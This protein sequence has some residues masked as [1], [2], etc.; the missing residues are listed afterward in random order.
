M[1]NVRAALA[2]VMNGSADAAIVYESDTVAAGSLKS[3]VISGP[4][5]PRIVYPAALVT[6]A[7]NRA[8]AQR[9]LAFLRSPAAAA[10][11]ARCKFTPIDPR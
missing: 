4:G 3:V 9:F 10:V 6:R 2:A 5:A 11:F 1:G 8:G 7:P